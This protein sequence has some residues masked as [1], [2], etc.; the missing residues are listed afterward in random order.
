MGEKKLEKVIG[1]RVTEEEEE[2]FSRIAGY[3]SMS[4]SEFMRWFVQ[5]VITAEGMIMEE[6]REKGTLA[7]SE[8]FLIRMNGHLSEWFRD[9]FLTTN[10][11]KR[12]EEIE[13]VGLKLLELAKMFR[14]SLHDGNIGSSPMKKEPEVQ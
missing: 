5:H 10:W 1:C 8:A 4:S 13:A 3:L 11:V 9:A 6:I 2:G 12:P 7:P 14:T